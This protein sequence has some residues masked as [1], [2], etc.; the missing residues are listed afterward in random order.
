MAESRE[1]AASAYP[2]DLPIGF[3][4]AGRLGSSLAIAMDRA[5]YNVISVS[6]RRSEH[7]DWLKSQLDSVAVNPEARDVAASSQIVFIT[8]SD[9][10][11]KEI[12]DS[13]TWRREQNVVHCSGAAPLEH[14]VAASNAGANTAGIHPMQT[15]PGR[16]GWDSF[17]G[18]TFG[19]EAPDPQ[20]RD[21]LVTLAARLGGNVYELTAD[22]R[23][24][25]HAAAVMACGLLAGLAGLAA[26]IWA[27]A[28]SIPRDK[29][30]AALTPLVKT[31]ANS[32]GEN[33][34]PKALTGP[35]VRGDVATVIAHLE[36]SSAVSSEFV[37]AYAS[38]ALATLP[39]AK[40]QGNLTAT[41]ENRI[42]ELL[43]TTLQISCEKI[44]QA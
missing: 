21:W 28:G 1:G 18:I 43:R 20:L 6:T 30:L 14:L 7:R 8:T 5:G 25:Y 15:F 44:E 34:L 40:E 42:K 17:R 31:T 36:A 27:S 19:I 32:L 37:A 13:I 33:G 22:Q 23:P 2:D 12:A 38:L 16:D 26:E 3:I 35:Y 24:A 10:A 4:G 9:G 29:A 11:I 41:D 39:M